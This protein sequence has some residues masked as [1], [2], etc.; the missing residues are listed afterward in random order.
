[1]KKFTFKLQP[2]L[3]LR[4]NKE[5]NIQSELGQLVGKQNQEKEKREALLGQIESEKNQVR[6]DMAAGTVDPRK[7]MV[8]EKYVHLARKA[9]HLSQDR[10]DSMEPAIDGVRKRLMEA[11]RE[12]LVVEKLKERRFAEYQY[13]YNREMARENDDINQKI[14]MRQRLAPGDEE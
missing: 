6:R 12:K 4:A 10:I 11:R 3:D 13:E 7:L 14:F 5:K 2:L 8:F 1:M 9:A